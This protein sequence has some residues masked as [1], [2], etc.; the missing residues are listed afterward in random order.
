MPISAY[1]KIAT[2]AAWGSKNTV[3]RTGG[4]DYYTYNIA[5]FLQDIKGVFDDT[6]SNDMYQ[7]LGTSRNT[8]DFSKNLRYSLPTLPDATNVEADQRAQRGVPE[9]SLANAKWSASKDSVPQSTPKVNTKLSFPMYP[10]LPDATN[11]EAELNEHNWGF[12]WTDENIRYNIAK[13][14]IK[15]IQMMRVVKKFLE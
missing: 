3:A 13:N 5:H 7:T 14:L 12:E 1:K 9:R 11:V 4:S 10:T 15:T 2:P 6:F 8:N